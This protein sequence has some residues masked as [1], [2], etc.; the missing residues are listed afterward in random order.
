DKR[1]MGQTA[2]LLWISGQHDEHAAGGDDTQNFAALFAGLVTLEELFRAV[3]EVV[4]LPT[5]HAREE[6]EDRVRCWLSIL[7]DAAGELLDQ[8]SLRTVFG[9]LC[10][11][12][13]FL[14]SMDATKHLRDAVFHGAWEALRDP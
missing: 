13:G 14:R 12:P 1:L 8:A 5:L 2:F 6:G 9:E 4:G 11:S 7:D 3:Y 10:D